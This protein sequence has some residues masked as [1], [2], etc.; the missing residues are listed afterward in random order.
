MKILKAFGWG[1]LALITFPLVVP[2]MICIGRIIALW[3][4]EAYKRWRTESPVFTGAF[5]VRVVNKE[6]SEC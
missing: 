1:L 4:P 5:N 2:P 3:K 6:K